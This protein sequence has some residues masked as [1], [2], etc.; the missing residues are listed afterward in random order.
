MHG[1]EIFCLWIKSGWQKLD[2]FSKFDEHLHLIK[3]IHCKLQVVV[4]AGH[5]HLILGTSF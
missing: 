3:A 1:M 5:C 4:L 2:T